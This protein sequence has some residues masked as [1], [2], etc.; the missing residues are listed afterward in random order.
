MLGK[1]RGVFRNGVVVSSAF[2]LLAGCATSGDW[3]TE[4]AGPDFENGTRVLGELILQATREQVVAN[5]GLMRGWREKL[6][7]AGYTNE[8][9]VDG[10]EVTVFAFCYGHNSGVP[11]CAHHGH[12][13][14]HVPVELRDGLHFDDDSDPAT[15]GDLVE[16]ELQRTA[17]GKIVGT[18]VGVYRSAEDWSPCRSANLE[19]GAVAS[20]ILALSS[21]GPPRAMWIECEASIEND[22][23]VR[24]PVPGAPPSS[25]PP[26]SQWFKAAL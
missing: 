4:T 12:F 2:G 15:S 23:W 13:V 6:L 25:G 20:T 17:S 16:V 9:I 24:R 5:E 21:V 22:G 7:E 3:Q 14:A 1:V 18:L 19:R 11:L 8:D 26:V 10:S